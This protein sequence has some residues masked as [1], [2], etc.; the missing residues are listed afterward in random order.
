MKIVRQ[1]IDMTCKNEKKSEGKMMDLKINK[2]K[3][4]ENR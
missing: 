4:S 1:V 3:N 2:S